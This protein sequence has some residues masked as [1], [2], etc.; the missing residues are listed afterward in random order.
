MKKMQALF[1]FSNGR[2]AAIDKKSGEIIW[3]IKINDYVKSSG[4]KYYGQIVVEDNKVFVGTAGILV[5][6]NAQDGA[7]L[8]KNELKGWGYQFVSMANAGSN[9]I[10]SA[11]S[12]SAATAAASSAATAAAIIATT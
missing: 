8:W 3:E 6:L 1:I 7:L 11:A 4:G 2:V 10:T 9:D 12:A 5:C